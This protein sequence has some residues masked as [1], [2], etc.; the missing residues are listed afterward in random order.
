M[1]EHFT[2]LHC[3]DSALF[4][5]SLAASDHLVCDRQRH[6]ALF[7]ADKIVIVFRASITNQSPLPMIASNR[8]LL[9]FGSGMTKRLVLNWCEIAVT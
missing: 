1:K 9:I 7:G 5:I 3:F 8:I 6:A 4:N 2:F